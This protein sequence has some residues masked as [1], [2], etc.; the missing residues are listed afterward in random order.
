MVSR[1]PT[2]IVI[3]AALVPAEDQTL[4]IVRA[5]SARSAF[6]CLDMAIFLCIADCIQYCP[7]FLAI[8]A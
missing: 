2:M 6:R 1:Y 7:F 5:V 3:Y 4:S 8:I